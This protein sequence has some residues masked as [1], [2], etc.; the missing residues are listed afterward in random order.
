MGRR[1]RGA[2]TDARAGPYASHHVD[3]PRSCPDSSIRHGQRDEHARIPLYRPVIDDLAAERVADVLRSGWLGAGPRTREVPEGAVRGDA[4]S[5]ALRR[6]RLGYRRYLPGSTSTTV[7]GEV[8]T[9]PVTFVSVNQAIL[10]E[11]LRPVF[12]D[13]DADT[14]NVDP[15]S[16]ERLVGDA[17]VA[18]VAMHYGGEPVI[19]TRCERSQQ[20]TRSRSSRM[21][22]T[23]A[24]RRTEVRRSESPASA[25]SRS[26]P[27]RTC[28]SVPVAR[29]PSSP[30]LSM[31]GCGGYEMP[32]STPTR[33]P[34]RDRGTAGTTPLRSSASG[35]VSTMC[36]PPSGSPSSTGLPPTTLEAQGS[37]S[38]TRGAGGGG[39]D[40]KPRRDPV[41][42][43]GQPL[44]LDP[45]RGS[46]R[47]DRPA[48]RRGDRCRRLLP[49]QL[50]LRAVRGRRAPG[51]E[52][53]WRRVVS[54]PLHLALS[55]DDVD[56]VIDVVRGG[57]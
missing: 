23:P 53:F 11:G 54:L 44:V 2:R 25:H 47:A 15:A 24:V 19:W 37:W 17:T 4:R 55:D 29:S 41:E 33:S 42:R 31:H 18:L 57:W 50:R 48:G 26:A 39:G 28:R 10:H 13:V 16:V 35:A 38:G 9:T 1:R 32:G 7:G 8:I 27:S 36:W 12:A 3:R 34:G 20:H 56:R 40:H 49:A 6:R 30:P 5:A 46:R 43:R 22:R 51:A 45:R 14:G 52:A 21:R